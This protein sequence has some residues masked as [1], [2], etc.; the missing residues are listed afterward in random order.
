MQMSYKKRAVNIGFGVG[1]GFIVVGLLMV[2]FAP[3]AWSGWATF[4]VVVG[5]VAALVGFVFAVVPA[6]DQ[7]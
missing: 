5:I 2:W 1:I 6:R 3:A 4:A 7:R